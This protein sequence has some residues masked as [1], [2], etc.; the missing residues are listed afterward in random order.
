MAPWDDGNDGT[1]CECRHRFVRGGGS[2]VEGACP[3]T[4]NVLGTLERLRAKPE[5]STVPVHTYA[6]PSCSCSYL[7]SFELESG[8]PGGSA[9]TC[10][11][12]A[13]ALN[14]LQLEDSSISLRREAPSP[15]SSRLATSRAAQRNWHTG[16]LLGN[17]GGQLD[18][19]AWEQKHGRRLHT[20]EVERGRTDGGR[21]PNFS[22]QPERGFP[23]LPVSE[24]CDQSRAVVPMLVLGRPDH[25]GRT[26][27]WT[28]GTRDGRERN[29]LRHPYTSS[30]P[31]ATKPAAWTTLTY[32]TT[33]ITPTIPI[34][35]VGGTRRSDA[36]PIER[37]T[38]K[39]LHEVIGREGVEERLHDSLRIGG[40][41]T[42]SNWVTGGNWVRDGGRACCVGTERLCDGLDRA[43]SVRLDEIED[44]SKQACRISQISTA[45]AS[46][47]V[48]TWG[49]ME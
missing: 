9:K 39:A 10:Q 46:D 33:F 35:R 42:T 7:A 19:D 17:I 13:A 27:L 8:A 23:R 18:I 29:A 14:L 41:S 15:E 21:P 37:R 28:R 38:E 26:H 45:T 49:N 16:R 1:S 44:R 47:Y 12:V 43:D 22:M 20:R 24:S 34:Q 30:G 32:R 5:T 3:I 6:A 2:W 11:G 40:S 4:R 36:D 48:R 25:P 31:A